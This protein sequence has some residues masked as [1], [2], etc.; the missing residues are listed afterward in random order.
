M[1]ELTCCHAE[2]R[3]CCHDGD[4]SYEVL[5]IGSSSRKRFGTRREV[6]AVAI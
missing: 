4:I 2:N 1:G 5:S 3:I 6:E